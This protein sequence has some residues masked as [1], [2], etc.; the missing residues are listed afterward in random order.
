M[1]NQYS[2]FSKDNVSV[3]TNV[4]ND[5]SIIANNYIYQYIISID[6]KETIVYV[7]TSK[8]MYSWITALF[9]ACLTNNIPAKKAIKILLM[10]NVWGD[11][12]LHDMISGNREY[13]IEYQK[14]MVLQ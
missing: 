11:K 8:I 4:P 5:Q 3:I 7:N 13:L 10:F 14:Y 9:L 2:S 1:F 6:N 12:S